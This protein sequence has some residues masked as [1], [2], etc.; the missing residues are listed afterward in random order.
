MLKESGHETDGHETDCY[1]CFE[2]TAF[3]SGTNANFNVLLQQIID[4]IQH[5]NV[6]HKDITANISITN[7]HTK[8]NNMVAKKLVDR[9]IPLMP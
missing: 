1:H 9:L 6:N 4:N 5:A 7:A 8:Y 3:I 2:F